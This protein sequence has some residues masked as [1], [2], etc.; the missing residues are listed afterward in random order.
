MALH[1]ALDYDDDEDDGAIDRTYL[2]FRVAEE[3]YAIS[4]I[5]VTEIVRLQRTY[6]MPDVPHYVR[7]VIN[8]RGRVL[9]LVDVR[10]RIH[11]E[12]LPYN[13]RTLIIVLADGS[14]TM[15]GLVVDSVD[16]VI[17]IPDEALEATTARHQGHAKGMVHSVGKIDDEVYFVMNLTA[18]LQD[19]PSQAPLHRSLAPTGNA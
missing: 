11:I 15:T 5:H 6:A 9:P 18:L 3:R 1:D 10:R 17:E 8:L 19:A 2:T 16:D 13:D 4:V 14:Q 7:G 12:D